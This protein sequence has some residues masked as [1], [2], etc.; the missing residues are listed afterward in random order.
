MAIE[1]VDP[2][3]PFQCGGILSL[4]IFAQAGAATPPNTAEIK[5]TGNDGPKQRIMAG[6]TDTT[7]TKVGKKSCVSHWSQ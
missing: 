7:G 5:I 1:A 3:I 2:T 6:A 4:I